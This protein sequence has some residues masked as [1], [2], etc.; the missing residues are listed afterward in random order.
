ML[1]DGSWRPKA[2]SHTLAGY[3]RPPRGGRQPLMTVAGAPM[4]LVPRF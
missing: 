1:P 2:A 4:L 3:G